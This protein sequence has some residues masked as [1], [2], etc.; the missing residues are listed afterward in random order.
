VCGVGGGSEWQTYKYRDPIL[1]LTQFLRS[2]QFP[3]CWGL[4]L[5]SKWEMGKARKELY[6]CGDLPKRM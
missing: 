6:S 4:P 1:S 3:G 5:F 2:S